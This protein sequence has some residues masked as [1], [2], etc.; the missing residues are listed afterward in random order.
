MVR[1]SI[2]FLVSALFLASSAPAWAYNNFSP[3]DLSGVDQSMVDEMLK[4]AGVGTA[5]RAFQPASNLGSLGLDAGI[6]VAG[7]V[8]PA[9]FQAAL[10]QATQQPAS[11]IPGV[12]PIPRLNVHKGF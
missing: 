6:D 3:G 7:T 5:F 12:I 1:T 2:R 4:V 9:D 11:Q 8:L 10:Q